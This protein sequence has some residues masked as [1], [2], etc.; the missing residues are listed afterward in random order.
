MKPHRAAVLGALLVA[1]ACQ[2]NRVLVLAPKAPPWTDSSRYE[3]EPP[4][5]LSRVLLVPPGGEE[6]EDLLSRVDVAASALKEF[7]VTLLLPEVGGG[8]PRL[9]DTQ[10]SLDLARRAEADAVLDVRTWKW[11]PSAEAPGGRRYFAE[12]PGTD[13]LAEVNAAAYEAARDEG[14]RYWY[15]NRV[16]D[17][18]G[19][20][21]DAET[22]QLLAD[23]RLRVPRVNVADTLV[24]E[25]RRDGEL[26]QETYS[27]SYDRIQRARIAGKAVAALFRRLGAV[28]GGTDS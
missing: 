28:L 19:R 9:L 25:F 4:L 20:V 11:V 21:L 15:G 5:G 7:G 13:T 17:F 14:V 2:H 24:A 26:V 12:Q 3:R 27:W 1:G 8:P 10:M 18:R 23:L 6:G 16:L 22:G